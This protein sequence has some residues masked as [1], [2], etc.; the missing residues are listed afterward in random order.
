M[1]TISQSSI[2][3]I[4][5]L[6]SIRLVGWKYKRK[7]QIQDQ[8]Q[9]WL[10]GKEVSS[11]DKARKQYQ[12]PIQ[13]Y[14]QIYRYTAVCIKQFWP[15]Y[16]T[17]KHDKFK[18]SASMKRLYQYDLVEP[19]KPLEPQYYWSSIIQKGININ[20]WIEII[21]NDLTEKLFPQIAL[22]KTAK[23]TLMSWYVQKI[24]YNKCFIS[25]YKFKDFP[26]KDLCVRIKQDF[27]IKNA[28]REYYKMFQFFGMT[29]DIVDEMIHKTLDKK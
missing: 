8:S 11:G 6:G 12:E 18:L 13:E 14:L 2:Q 28:K 17:I 29:Q 10:R 19:C 15:N 23:N 24:V 26:K 5:E 9:E 4:Q 20:N 1:K 25:T 22:Y 3:R 7:N 16:S 27:E 21:D